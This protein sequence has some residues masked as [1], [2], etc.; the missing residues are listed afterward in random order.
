MN[1]SQAI[2]QR[3]SCRAFTEQS[4]AIDTIKTIIDTAKYAPSGVNTQPWQVAVL[5]GESKQKLSEKMVEAFRN[6]QTE[7]MDYHYYPQ[8][9]TELYKKRRVAT[10]IKLYEALNI[11]REDKARRLTQ[12]EANYR[13]FDAPVMLLFFIDKS[14]ETGSY[15]DYGMFLQNIMLLAEEQGLATCPQGALGEFPSI[16]KAHLEIAE[17]WNLLG[18]MALGY[19]DKEHPVNSYR[20]DRVELEEFCQFFE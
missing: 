13:A 16:V 9:W 14:L 17:N 19:E 3:H 4:V 18:G 1:V 11:Q 7:S 6:K 20:T 2:K 15:L 12:W 10:G 8:T 5:S